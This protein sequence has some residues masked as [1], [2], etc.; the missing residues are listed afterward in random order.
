MSTKVKS[1]VDEST[2]YHSSILE[3][4]HTQQQIGLNVDIKLS[5][6][7]HSVFAHSAMLLKSSSTLASLLQTPCFCSQPTV[8]ILPPVYSPILSDFVSLLYSGY[9][10]NISKDKVSILVNLATEL[11]I[12]NLSSELS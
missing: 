4:L 8:L 9:V 3:S 10:E 12:N 5:S 1:L 11:G 7:D 2:S 6:G